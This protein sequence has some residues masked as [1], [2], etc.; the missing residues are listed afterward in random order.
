[1]CRSGGID[2]SAFEFA[3][4]IVQGVGVTAVLVTLYFYYRQL[5][6]MDR[7]QLAIE[8]EMAARMRPWVGLFGFEFE[9]T[10]AADGPVDV[11][12]VLLRNCGAL[13]AQ[14][15]QLQLVIRPAK[16]AAG[17]VD[18]PI[19]W[20]EQS[21]KA[22]VPGEDGKYRIELSQHPQFGQWRAARRDV[23]IEGAMSYELDQTQFRTAFEAV[24]RFSES[25]D[26]AGAVKTRW[27]NQEVR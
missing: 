22:L 13:P 19:H 10:I 12:R 3:Q 5:H 6:T 25:P 26:A 14:G 1:M 21:K 23:V 16:S 8:R 15:A 24:L 20:Q 7:Q 27:R 17:E 4:L 18:R 9:S 2:L 11:L